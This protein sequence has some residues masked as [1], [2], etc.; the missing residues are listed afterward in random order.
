VR[1]IQRRR[2]WWRLG[3]PLLP[4]RARPWALALTA[5]CVVI[6]VVI[7]LLVAR[8]APLGLDAA[9][10][11]P[12]ISALG[13]HQGALLHV[14]WLGSLV[15]VTIFSV[16]IVIGCLLAG[17]L[18]GA[19]LGALTVPIADGLD[20]KLLK[21]LF[22]RADLGFLSY[23]SGHTTAV[24]AL[25]SVVTVLLAF[26]APGAVRSPLRQVL[27][28]AAAVLITCIVAVALIALGWHYF[29]DI[30]GG[31]AVAIG[32]VSGLILLLDLP[33]TRR[34][35]TKIAPYRGEDQPPPGDTSTGTAGERMARPRAN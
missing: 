15:P 8:R 19:I 16:L 4:A 34:I 31:A 1:Q 7:G 14:V 5:C 25:G 24:L 26:P 13:S 22:H 35:L 6:T 9:I 2:M 32:T 28:P 18:N 3:E 30:I 27:I 21:P 20:E 11:T 12:I 33:A 23:P 10:D 17:R 29:T